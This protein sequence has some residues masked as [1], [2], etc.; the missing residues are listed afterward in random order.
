VRLDNFEIIEQGGPAMLKAWLLAMTSDAK[1]AGVI[2]EFSRPASL[3]ARG[4][5]A[6]KNASVGMQWDFSEGDM[7]A[8]QAVY[9]DAD[10]SRDQTVLKI[11]LVPAATDLVLL[12]SGLA[13][14]TLDFEK[15]FDY[16]TGL[17]EW[18]TAHSEA[19]PAL[20]RKKET[21]Q[22]AH[23]HPVIKEAAFRESEEWGAW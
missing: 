3:P 9:Q 2:F 8:V 20:L 6:G 7:L 22:P 10:V 23:S 16:L 14:V 15:A 17:K 19:A 1:K 11:T 13:S 21:P 5:P 18:A 12:R 4:R